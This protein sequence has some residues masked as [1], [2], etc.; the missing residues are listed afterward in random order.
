LLLGLLNKYPPFFSSYF[1]AFSLLSYSI[2]SRSS[3]F[4]FRKQKNIERHVSKQIINKET[5][6]I[7]KTTTLLSPISTV[8]ASIK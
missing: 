3:A 4:I 8:I 7:I 1:L 2:F 5:A 6:R